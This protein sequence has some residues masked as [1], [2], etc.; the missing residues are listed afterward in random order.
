MNMHIHAMLKKIKENRQSA[1][2]VWYLIFRDV[3]HLININTTGRDASE[4][5]Q[6]KKKLNY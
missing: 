6:K 5:R 1:A 4:E 2:K 3:I